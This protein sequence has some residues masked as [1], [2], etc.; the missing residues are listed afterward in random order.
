MSVLLR[1]L[2]N[3]IVKHS[4]AAKEVLRYLRRTSNKPLIFNC[5]PKAKTTAP[6]S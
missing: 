5:R 4:R 3:P 6:T 2:A 1:H